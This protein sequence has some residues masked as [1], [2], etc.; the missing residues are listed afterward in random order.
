MCLAECAATYVVN[1]ECNDCD[2]LPAPESDVTSTKITLT[3][4]MN[5]RS[6]DKIQKV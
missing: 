2:A 3:G 4:K 1:Y 5:K 6:C